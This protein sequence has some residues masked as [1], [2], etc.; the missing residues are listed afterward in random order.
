MRRPQRFMRRD[1]FLLM[2]LAAV[3]VSAPGTIP[4]IPHDLPLLWPEEQ[5][6]FLQDGPG[7]LLSESQIDTLINQD[8]VGREQFIAGFL[9]G[10]PIPETEVNELAEGIERRQQLVGEEFV[11]Y[12]DVRAKL[13]FLH[14]QPDIRTVVDCAET[15]KPLEIWSYRDAPDSEAEDLS[16]HLIESAAERKAKRDQE[17]SLVERD[18]ERERER[19]RQR[20][21]RAA[22][23]PSSYVYRKPPAPLGPAPDL[24]PEQLAEKF[25]LERHRHL[26][27]YRPKPD[28]GYRLWLPI[29]SKRQIYNQE[30]EYWLEQWE[31][32]RSRIRGGRRFDRFVC[33]YSLIV[34]MVTGIDGLF[35]FQPNRPKNAELQAYLVPPD[36]L[37]IWALNA[38]QTPVK[39]IPRLE[40]A[41]LDIYFPK[42][43]GQRM[44]TQG[45]VTLPPEVELETF[46]EGETSEL[47]LKI[48][49]MLEREGKIFDE[50][51]MR[52]QLPAPPEGVDVPVALVFDRKLRPG[53]DFIMRAKVIEEISGKEVL[54]SR[55]FR[56]PST[57]TEMDKPP[58]PEEVLTA[59]GKSLDSQ[60]I[61]G[62]DSLVVVP[63]ESDVVFGLWR[64]EALVTGTRIVKVAFLLDGK[65]QLTRRRPPFTAELRLSE[66]PTEQIVRVEG[67]DEAG[68]VV[69]SDEVVLNQPRGELRVRIIEPPRGRTA[70]GSVKA[71]AEVVVP[72]EKNVTQVEF[73]VNDKLQVTIENPPWEAEVSVPP[74]EEL[75]YMTVAATLN[76]GARAE[77]VRF[78]V[79]PDYIEE[80]DVNLIELYTTVTD[81]NGLLI[82][83]LE[84][85]E[86]KVWED[87]RPQQIAK[88][89]LVE[90]LPLTL[91]IT[92]DTSGSM[93]ESLGEAQRA[94][95]GFLESIITPR[96]RCFALAFAD[97]PALLM[98]R[99]SDVGAV[100]EVLENLVANGST[101]LHDAIVTS[102]YYYRGVR[103]RR[104]LVLLSDG[105]DTSSSL[106][107]EESL[108]YAKR[109]GVS[110]FAIGLRIGKA[111]VGA[112]RK[113]EKLASE[114]GGR[115]FYI[116][117][118]SELASVYKDIERELRSQYLVAYSSDQQS[119]SGTYHEVEIKVRDG[120]LKARTIRGYYS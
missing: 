27:V 76:D 11:S 7:L 68:E 63:P 33:D 13:L 79:A 6:S 107:F 23:L 98:Q 45:V 61:P 24:T 34:D 82:R 73:L 86:F 30:M 111:D 92:I 70:R 99:T 66:F 19:E 87:G 56:V 15:F 94:A 104:A 37:T 89:E 103:G 17:Q 4:K 31:E 120:K 44:V 48:E 96:D 118:A 95:I 119:E 53:N 117:E 88:F 67:Y 97:R 69:A 102:L 35:G 62:Y 60:R 36:D 20:R 72:E 47:R 10:D 115:T 41:E 25:E 38:S 91:G 78:L 8:T 42:R 75:V 29:D 81:K 26:V 1:V 105:D 9:A 49:G 40:A 108:E 12:L 65:V 28:E 113:L 52:F 14:G 90:D 51:R 54:L 43:D 3:A 59:I 22:G 74:G 83:G 50:F 116:K 100:A 106:E 114:T 55:G 85:D 39:E 101:S 64:A 93:F 110:V 32:L 71:R 2:L 21:A 109:S 5:R 18:R 84:K 112:R 16:R 57:A 80:V 77:D 46:Q 58:I